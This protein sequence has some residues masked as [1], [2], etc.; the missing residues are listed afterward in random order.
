MEDT[1]KH[2]I[3]F[4][5]YKKKYIAER[6]KIS[7]NYLSMCLKGKRNLSEEKKNELKNILK[8]D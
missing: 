7:P 6:L 5:G 1:I 3:K 8:N 4:S 2:K